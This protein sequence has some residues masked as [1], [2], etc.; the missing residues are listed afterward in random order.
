MINDN[1]FYVLSGSRLDLN[2]QY[3]WNENGESV[4]SENGIFSSDIF[5]IPNRINKNE[6]PIFIMNPAISFK[7]ASIFM[8][9]NQTFIGYKKFISKQ[10]QIELDNRTTQISINIEPVFDTEN[11]KEEDIKKQYSQKIW[12]YVGFQ[13]VPHY[14]NIKLKYKKETNQEFFRETIDGSIKLFG[15]DFDYINNASIESEMLF[16]IYNKSNIL[17]SINKFSKVDCKLNL[18]KKLVELKLSAIDSYTNIM[19]SYENTYDLLKIGVPTTPIELYKRFAIQTYILGAD[20][21]S[22]FL[23]NGTYF[24]DD[25]NEVIDDE[26]ELLNKYYFAKSA[27]FYEIN[28]ELPIFPNNSLTFKCNNSDEWLSPAYTLYG[29]TTTKYVTFIKLTKV[30]SKGDAD[31]KDDY[32]VLYSSDLKYL[33][34]GSNGSMSLQYKFLYDVYRVELRTKTYTNGIEDSGSILRYHSTTYYYIKPDSWYVGSNVQ[35]KMTKDYASGPDEYTIDGSINYSIYARLVCNVDSFS[36]GS[37][38]IKTYDYP[39]DDFI[40]DKANYKKCIGIVGNMIRIYQSS[41]TVKWPTKFGINDIGEYFTSNFKETSD[42]T[43]IFNKPMPISR[44]SW[45]NTSIWAIFDADSISILDN[46]LKEQ[47]T[48]KDAYKLSDVIKA[49]LNKIDI[50]IKHSNSSSFSNFLYGSNI[51]IPDNI[52][53][54]A[55][56]EVFIIPKSNILKGNYDQAAQ[57]AEITL[58]QVMDMLR[59]CFKAYWLI[60]NYNFKIEHIKYFDNGYSYSDNKNISQNAFYIDKF[61]KQNSLYCQTELS[62]N[63]SDLQS[64]FE[65]G[66]MDDSS[67]IFDGP[68][69]DVISSYVQKDKVETINPGNFSSDIDLML[70]APD[71]FSSDGFALI[72]ATKY[73]D[74]H[75]ETPIVTVNSLHDEDYK[76]PYDVK[77]QNYYASWT[78]LENYYMYNMPA[79]NI[80][81]DLLLKNSFSIK[82]IYKCMSHDVEFQSNNI[83]NLKSLYKTSIGNGK[84]DE[85]TYDIDTH[86]TSMTLVYEPK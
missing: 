38:V 76:F 37:S 68:K 70:L 57:K 51:S 79:K 64:R 46:A 21:Y 12:F 3:M 24:E 81:Y 63:K 62:Y 32:G 27:A 11:L 39:Y 49:I 43:N 66:W 78:F 4:K 54:L 42:S 18:T 19:D 9:N 48:I 13:V 31:S 30:K 10:N 71:K 56:R 8:F 41:E 6:K 16:A 17:V 20:S 69:I 40:I 23:S 35:I 7:S 53:N 29:D 15:K 84:V 2:D 59:Y 80:E 36:Y 55:N 5:V 74:G 14:K 33:H 73:G 82:S 1:K 25:V 26:K 50:N 86:H 85:M 28:V 67:D 52:S 22:C 83:L 47:Y 75:Y 72:V 45:G 44:S 65:F 34:D 58:K 60:D 61:N 77:V